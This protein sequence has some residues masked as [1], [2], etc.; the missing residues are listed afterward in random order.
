ML[1]R[2]LAMGLGIGGLVLAMSACGGDMK[3]TGGSMSGP[4]EKSVIPAQLAG[5]WYSGDRQALTREIEGYLAAVT[6]APLPDVI[7]L[8][9]PH[10][11]VRF[12]GQ[13]AAYGYKQVAGRQFSRVIVMGPTHRTAMPNQVSIPSSSHYATPLGEIPLDRE[14][15]ARLRA[16]PQF[17]DNPRSLIQENSVEIQ[18]PLLQVALGEF[19]LVPIVVGQLDEAAAIEIAGILRAAIDPATLIVSSSDFTHYGPRFQYEPFGPGTAENIRQ[20]DMGAIEQIKAKSLKGFMAYCGQ[21]GATICGHDPISVLIAMLP[22][23]AQAT[24]LHYDTSGR[25]V[26][27]YEDSVSYASIAFTGQWTPGAAPSVAPAA[28]PQEAPILTEQDK[29]ELLKLAR[30]TIAFYFKHGRRPAL[31]DLGITV[32][33][34]MQTVMGAFVTLKEAGDLRGCIGEIFPRRPLVEA[35]VEQALNAAFED[36]RFAPL[37]ADEL[38]LIKIEI[39][40]L[41]PPHPV[42][43][44]RDIV[45]GK[46][47]M[48]LRKG[49][50]SAVFLPQVAPEQGWDLP[51]TLSHLAMKAGLP[52]D[53]WKQGADFTVFE[54]IVFNEDEM[55]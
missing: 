42:P 53:A 44:Y 21:T 55:K 18:L 11:G 36:P 2:S 7:A 31:R 15:I 48:V 51:T 20:L 33:P 12:S 5:S 43:S 37:D 35:V 25:M 16:Y 52:A 46:H 26:G 22:E 45:I 23:N 10:A 9:A 1:K 8:I 6:G 27:D 49:V 40:A 3:K 32:T 24:L 13:V 34:G 30:D 47:G 28:N 50:R 14:F 29:K 54:A 39:S 17:I 41:T 4:A 38:P 19:K